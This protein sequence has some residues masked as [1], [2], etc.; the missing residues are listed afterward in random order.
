MAVAT[1]R[2]LLLNVLCFSFTMQK[3]G[4]GVAVYEFLSNFF[5]ML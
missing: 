1:W 4:G 5:Y 2:V 3:Y